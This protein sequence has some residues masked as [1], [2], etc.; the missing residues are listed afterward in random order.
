[1]I[2]YSIKFYCFVWQYRLAFLFVSCT[3]CPAVRG[4]TGYMAAGFSTKTGSAGGKV[5]CPAWILPFCPMLWG[6]PS[7]PEFTWHGNLK[8]L[9]PLPDKCGVQQIFLPCVLPPSLCRRPPRTRWFYL[10]TK[11]GELTYKKAYKK[12]GKPKGSP[13]LVSHRR[14]ELRT[15]CLKGNCSAD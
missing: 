12:S 14:F 4:V 8:C 11:T 13:L 3:A 6:Y 7:T 9:L 15:H 10:T 1:M 5:H 2:L